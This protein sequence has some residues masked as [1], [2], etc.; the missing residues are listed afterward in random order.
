MDLGQVVS[1]L[2]KIYQEPLKD[3]EKRKIVFWMDP[4]KSFTED[5]NQIEIID[6]KIHVMNKSNQF[7]TKYLLEEKDS[8]SHYLIYTNLDLDTEDNWLADTVF[9]SQTFYADKLSIIMNELQID[10]SFR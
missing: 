10:P 3:G 1:A 7:Y 6:V 5:I 2:E 8:D 4:E 9:Y